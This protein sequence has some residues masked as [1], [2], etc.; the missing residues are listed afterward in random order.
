[1]TTV[2]DATG[3][4]GDRRRRGGAP[5]GVQLP[6]LTRADLLLALIPLAFA[7][8]LVAAGTLPLARREALAIASAFG[9]TAIFDGV[10]RNPPT[11]ER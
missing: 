3:H 5:F 4:L 2:S 10:V 1:M 7:V 8:A 9:L 11:S 6:G